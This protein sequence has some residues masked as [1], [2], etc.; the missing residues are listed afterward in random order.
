MKYQFEFFTYNTLCW[1][2]GISINLLKHTF[3]YSPDNENNVN[4]ITFDENII[5]IKI[6]L[7]HWRLSFQFYKTITKNFKECM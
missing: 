3:N 6:N 2:L 5:I 1:S 4:E 7:L